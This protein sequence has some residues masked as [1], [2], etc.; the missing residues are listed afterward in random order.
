M[1]RRAQRR[2]IEQDLKESLSRK[3][4]DETEQGQTVHSYYSN[5]T[6]TRYYPESRIRKAADD[7]DNTREHGGL[8]KD[9][10]VTVLQQTL[11][12]R[13]TFYFIP[14]SHNY[15]VRYLLALF[16]DEC[17]HHC[18][19]T[20]SGEPYQNPTI[21]PST[22][23]YLPAP[24][25]I[26]EVLNDP[27]HQYS[28]NPAETFEQHTLRIGLLLKYHYDTYRTLLRIRALSDANGWEPRLALPLQPGE[29]NPTDTSSD[30]NRPPAT[31]PIAFP[32]AFPVALPND[33]DTPHRPTS[34]QHDSLGTENQAATRRTANEWRISLGL[35]PLPEIPFNRNPQGLINQAVSQ[36]RAEQVAR[37]QS[38]P[39]GQG[40]QNQHHPA[41]TNEAPQHTEPR[42][43]THHH[44]RDLRHIFKAQ[45]R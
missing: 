35:D 28:D 3:L 10:V 1:A 39:P 11:K 42:D 14:E 37:E 23:Q 34:S 26:N 25:I 40:Q 13:H 19:I 16:M 15:W 12:T 4:R 8:D 5:I 38:D 17:I 32:V 30:S 41:E 2:T 18:G 31:T 24:P 43:D 36:A 9:D 22:F 21:T 29:N 6:S 20:Y 45:G 44:L 33:A 27:A 7:Y